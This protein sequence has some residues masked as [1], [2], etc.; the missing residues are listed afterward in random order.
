MSDSQS[1][2]IEQRVQSAIVRALRLRSQESTVP[3][4]MGSTPGWD[5]MGHMLVVIEVEKEF[6]AS[7]P[8]YRLPEL[9]DVAS[10][11]K[12]IQTQQAK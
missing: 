1:Q 12:A 7:F 9:L 6:Q 5:S 8:P 10:I 4:R 3:L 2:G 11:V